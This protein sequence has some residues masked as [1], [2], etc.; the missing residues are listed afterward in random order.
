[1]EIDVGGAHQAVLENVETVEVVASGDVSI[2]VT[3]STSG[4]GVGLMDQHMMVTNPD[5]ILVPTSEI[6]SQALSSQ[7][8][9]PEASSFSMPGMG[10]VTIPVEPSS[11]TATQG[12]ILGTKRL[13]PDSIHPDSIPIGH[14]SAATSDA[15]E[16]PRKKSRNY[17]DSHKTIE[18]KRRD[19]INQCLESLKGLVPDCRQYGSKKLDKA[20]IL[21]MCIEYIQK[22]QRQ[23]GDRKS[24]V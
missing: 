19:R 20:E 15:S 9:D 22:M 13:H 12:I 5:G 23:G 16:I 18:K 8:L 6:E 10:V 4:S 14:L 2:P 1:M 11:P 17:L 21:E 24:V 7:V 3:S